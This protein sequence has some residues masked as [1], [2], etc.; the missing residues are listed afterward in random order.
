M[1]SSPPLQAEKLT[2]QS[3]NQNEAYG[4]GGAGLAQSNVDPARTGQHDCCLVS[5]TFGV[6]NIAESNV[7]WIVSLD[8]MF[9]DLDQGKFI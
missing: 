6:I 4:K 5:L 7:Y 8:F 2:C 1:I 9:L 3:K